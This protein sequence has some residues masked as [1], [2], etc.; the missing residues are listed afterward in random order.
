MRKELR[1]AFS[2][3]LTRSTSY[4]FYYLFIMDLPINNEELK[5]LMDALNESN[6]PDAMKRQFRNELH[7]KL[8]LT[9]FLIEEGYPHKKVLRE[10]FD[11]VA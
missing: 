8:R 2:R 10:V 11:I 1:V 9:K 6:H 4:F 5:E 3:F 7:R